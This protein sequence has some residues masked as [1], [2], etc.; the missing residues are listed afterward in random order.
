MLEFLALAPV[1]TRFDLDDD[2]IA[3]IGQWIAETNVR[4]GLDGEHREPWGVPA[5]YTA[6]SW[7]AALD[8]LLM[9]VAVSEDDWALAA[10]EIAPL[11]V[12]GS[13]ITVAGRLAD[14]LAHLAAIADDVERAR[15]AAEWCAT[16]LDVTGRLFAVEPAQQWQLDRLRQIIADIAEAATVGERASAVELTLAD[17]RRLLVERLQ[18][19]PRRPD[20]FR[21]GITFSSLTPLR[22]LPF[23]VV[24]L[25][26]LDE[27]AMSTGAVDGDDLAAL[28]AAPRR[29]RPAR[30][31]APDPARSG[32]RGAGPPRHHPHRPQHPH[33]PGGA[34]SRSRSPSCATRSPPRSPAT[35]DDTFTT[36]IETVHPHQPFDA[37][38]FEPG[39][40]R[41]GPWSFDA[42][43]LDGAQARRRRGRRGAAVPRRAARRAGRPGAGDHAR[44]AAVL[45]Q[46][47]GEV[48]L[49]PPARRSTSP[50]RKAG[51]PTTCRS[52]SPG[53]SEWSAAHRLIEARLDGRTSE[54]VGAPRAGARHAPRRRA[55][56]SR[57]RRD[58]RAVDALLATTAAL[59]VDPR[60]DDPQRDRR[61][62]RR[63]HPGRRRGRAPLRLGASRPGPA[64]LQQGA[65]EAAPRGVAR[66]P[67]A[68]RPGPDDDW[69]SVHVRR[70]ARRHE[71][72]RA[73]A[74]RPRRRPPRAAPTDALAA[75]AVVVDLYR[76][77][78][79]E[80]IPLFSQAVAQALRRRGGGR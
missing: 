17:L 35:R 65:A 11:G 40:L 3:V 38:C 9:G 4:W 76:R 42:T 49:R 51:C 72:G 53:S 54:R 1:R 71:A 50:A 47:P 48:L 18:G 25:L 77:G 29:P 15:A 16:L 6:N 26:G 64:H 67:G 66:S 43:A 10:G 39:A 19:A 37:R 13:D 59:G 20:F 68:R 44:R 14:V 46:P 8:R 45:P 33:Q 36:A 56:R 41:A 60:H 61:R 28:G 2:A 79:R 74:R 22:W 70:N 30:R 5:G 80:P 31:A 52:R 7:R 24:C 73:G 55:R 34:R 27:G 57:A 58:H 62:A 32:A 69:R 75:L 21:G 78:L 63:R 23:R 12:E